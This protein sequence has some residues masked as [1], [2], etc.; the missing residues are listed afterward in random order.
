VPVTSKP[1]IFT[2][3]CPGDLGDTEV[4]WFGRQLCVSKA[5]GIIKVFGALETALSYIN[6]AIVTCKRQQK[7]LT[8]VYW[9]LFNLGFYLSTGQGRYYNISLRLLKKS[10]KC[11]YPLLPDTPLG[12][13]ICLDQ[14]CAAINNARV[15]VR[16]AERRLAAVEDG[17]EA[18]LILNHLGNILFELMRTAT[19]G[20]KGQGRYIVV[21]PQKRRSKPQ[22]V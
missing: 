14:C 5:S 11:L 22:K 15:W 12:W 1:C 7:C 2:G 13:I 10:L 21:K 19:H 3:S 9:A 20:V 4:L 8:R 18:I 17:R 16:W 6:T